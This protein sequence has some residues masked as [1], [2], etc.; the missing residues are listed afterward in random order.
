MRFFGRPSL[1]GAMLIGATTFIAATFS[2]GFGTSNAFGQTNAAESRS[3]ETTVELGVRKNVRY[4]NSDY[5]FKSGGKTI[6]EHRNYIDLV[7]EQG[8]FR[9]NNVGNQ[10][11]TAAYMGQMTLDA[12]REKGH[13]DL[14]WTKDV[15]KP[16][17]GHCYAIKVTEDEHEMVVYLVIDEINSRGVKFR[18]VADSRSGWPGPLQE[19]LAGESGLMGPMR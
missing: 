8:Y 14:T 11:N 6:E 16:V 17:K 9:I 5:S 4:G 2:T 7:Y 12:A 19:G 15:F 1:V 13:A 3:T 18:W 10:Q